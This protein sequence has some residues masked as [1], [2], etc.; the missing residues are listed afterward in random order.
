MTEYFIA[1]VVAGFIIWSLC[2][3]IGIVRKVRA[4]YVENQR[5]LCTA[6]RR[7]EL[8]EQADDL[9]D[10]VDTL[11]LDSAWASESWHQGRSDLID[12]INAERIQEVRDE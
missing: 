10:A 11:D 12:A 1:I 6:A 4:Y 5:L 2:D 8:L 7:M 9:L 3:C